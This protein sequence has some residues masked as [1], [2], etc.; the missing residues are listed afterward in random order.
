MARFDVVFEGGGAQGI[1][2]AGALEVLYNSGHELARLLGTSAG[3][4]TAT[5][6][7]AGFTTDEMLASVQERVGGK[8]RFLKFMDIP[9]EDPLFGQSRDSYFQLELAYHY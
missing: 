7:A 8:P 6:C 9:E 3:A 1:A 2:F 5:L 4:I